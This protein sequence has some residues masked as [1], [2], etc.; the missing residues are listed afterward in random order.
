MMAS[1]AWMRRWGTGGGAITN[2]CAPSSPQAQN[3]PTSPKKELQN[4]GAEGMVQNHHL[5]EVFAP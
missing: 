5:C 1:S 3:T 4:Y 2:V